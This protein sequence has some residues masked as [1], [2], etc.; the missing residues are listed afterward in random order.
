MEVDI[1]DLKR[2]HTRIDEMRRYAVEESII[3][4]DRVRFDAVWLLLFAVRKTL[5]GSDDTLRKHYHRIF[6]LASVQSTLTNDEKDRKIKEFFKRQFPDVCIRPM[7]TTVNG[8][9]QRS[10]Q[11]EDGKELYASRI[12]LNL[13]LCAVANLDEKANYWERYR[14]RMLLLVTIYHELA[15]AVFGY[16]IKD[17]PGDSPAGSQP[18]GGSEFAGWGGK[19]ESG[20]SIEAVMFGGIISPYWDSKKRYGNYRHISCLAIR[21]IQDINLHTPR[22]PKYLLCTFSNS[23]HHIVA[24]FADQRD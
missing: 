21:R 14:A 5:C 13:A 22:R 2:T 12:D 20:F 8:S 6:D 3:Y 15:H 16:L 19:G 1:T 11:K 9:T 17:Q 23:P 7:P 24:S 10:W 4:V 18:G